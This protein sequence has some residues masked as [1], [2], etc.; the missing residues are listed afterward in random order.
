[1]QHAFGLDIPESAEEACR[2][3]HAAL[4]VYDMQEGIL[5]HVLRR[6]ALV[7]SVQKVIAAARKSS[8]PVLYVRHVSL[9]PQIAGVAALRAAMRWQ[10]VSRVE[11]VRSAFPP[12][13]PQTQIV[14]EVS[15]RDGEAVFNKLAMSA[16]VG[17]PLDQIFR[18]RRLTAFAI[19]GA[20][21]EIGIE[22]TIRHGA[23][24]G[25]VP[26]L[27]EDACG[28]VDEDAARRAVESLDY[29]ELS[30]RSDAATVSEAFA[31]S[32]QARLSRS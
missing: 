17:T 8:V 14:P 5:R 26:V 3:G 22:P 15:P 21:L 25:Y 24:L 16:F 19:V 9:P 2:P 23:D 27:V 31:G 32:A 29:A 6:D 11:D 12:E 10:R 1:M 30:L 18:D 28:V 7:A 4:I 20:V 13:E